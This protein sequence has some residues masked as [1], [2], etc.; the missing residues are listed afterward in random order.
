[1]GSVAVVALFCYIASLAL[2]ITVYGAKLMVLRWYALAGLMIT[3]GL[4]WASSR[5]G[6][7]HGSERT[8]NILVV[9]YL[10]ATFLS[11]ISAENQLFS[12]LRWLSHAFMLVALLVLL[13]NSLNAEHT[14]A[15]FLFL[16]GVIA[17]LLLVSWLNPISPVVMK[18]SQLYRGA[19]GCSNAMGQI[20][21]TGAILYL[22]GFLIEKQK[23]WLRV[24]QLGMALLALWIMWSSG[25]R[26]ALVAFLAGLAA[27][28]Y[29]YPKIIRGKILFVAL[30]ATFSMFAF[31]S[32]PGNIRQVILRE[33]KP[34]RSIS[35][36]LL[37]TRLSV[38][39]ASWNGFQKRP[40]FGWGFGADDGI[41]SKWE[42]QL[43]AL[44]TV[45]RDNVNDTLVI[46]EGAGVVGLGA[47]ILLVIFVLRQ[48]PTRSERHLLARLHSPPSGPKGYALSNYNL[49]AITFIIG[50]ALLLMVQFDNTALSAGNFVSVTLWLCV[51]LAGAIRKKVMADEL[52]YQRQRQSFQRH[53]TAH[54]QT[55]QT[56]SGITN[57]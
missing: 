15:I 44:G 7:P 11:V 22:H 48:I 23:R 5:K 25:S 2:A 4:Y 40:L 54:V 53:A 43:V 49:H 20:A 26:S 6:Q 52:L 35:E 57:A 27:M 51:A 3:S 18:T 36:Q 50:A 32:L 14:A 28:N 34:A 1:M 37:V 9:A 21:T 19:L 31:P 42:T 38:W 12:G 16:K 55:A 46:M 8:D 41:A 33:D 56:S 47:Y 39:T 24:G 17:A 29:F 10:M 13:K 45:A 30:V